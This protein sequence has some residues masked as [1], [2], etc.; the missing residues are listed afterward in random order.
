[1]LN[2]CESFHILCIPLYI[3][4]NKNYLYRHIDKNMWAYKSDWE[5]FYSE[6]YDTS[7]LQTT[8]ANPPSQQLSRYFWMNQL[9]WATLFF[10]G[11]LYLEFL[12]S[13]FRIIYLC[14]F[15]YNFLFSVEHFAI[16]VNQLFEDIWFTAITN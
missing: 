13:S 10:R 1:M 12:P 2:R 7:E 6:H 9:S 15:F 4:P 3:Y 5:R 14:G 11:Y 8:F 16:K